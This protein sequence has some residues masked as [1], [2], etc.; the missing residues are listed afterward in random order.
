[1]NTPYVVHARPRVRNRVDHASVMLLRSV[2]AEEQRPEDVVRDLLAVVGGDRR[3][4]ALMRAKLS[5]ATA[6]RPTTITRRAIRVLDQALSATAD[7]VGPG[8]VAVPMQ[9]GRHD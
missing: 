7:Q 1:M 5:K 4:L 6:E 2:M 8:E 3:V 9:G